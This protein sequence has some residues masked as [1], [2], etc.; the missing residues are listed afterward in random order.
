MSTRKRVII[1]CGIIAIALG[2]AYVFKFWP[3]ASRE[4]RQAIDIE[5]GTGKS[6]SAPEPMKNT[7]PVSPISGL[8]CDNW[9]R[10]PVAVM[11]PADVQTRPPAGF[12]QADM[13]FE[14]PTPA[15]DVM[16][17][18]LMGVYLCNT[19]EDIGSIRS[20][21]HDFI[22]MAGGLN[23][24]FVGW[25]GSAFALHKLNEGVIDNIDCN[26]QGGKKAPECC[27]RKPLGQDGLNRVEDTGYVKGEKIFACAGEFG[28][29]GKPNTFSGYPHQEEAKSE[30][31]PRGG[32]LRVG[33]PTSAE[34]E[35]DYDPS[36]NSYLRTWGGV[37]DTDRNTKSRVAPKNVVVMTAANEQ[38][39]SQVDYSN[40]PQDPWSG[41]EDWEK[42]GP[43]NISGRYNNLQIGDPWFDT[44]DSGDAKFYFNGEEY[45]GTWKKDKSSLSNKLTF[46]DRSGKEI[47]FVPGQIWVNVVV[48]GMQVE[49]TPQA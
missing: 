15:S 4:P 47:L 32:H 40:R 10:R 18:R 29:M 24:V 25:G 5:N 20:T 12:S 2:I 48:P 9:N 23:A 38:I 31:R 6:V 46:F 8:P 45:L 17:T 16:V 28:Y 22:A 35:Y 3:F 36:T 1:W 37:P 19:P 33:Y 14:M 27:Y 11:Q 26:G 30:V 7:G 34:A 43:R 42:N 41:L 13:V 21:R 39:M 49:W 44:L